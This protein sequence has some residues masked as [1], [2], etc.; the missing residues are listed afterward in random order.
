[1]KYIDIHA[2][3]Y[4]KPVPFVTEFCTAEELVRRYDK[5][6]IEAGFVLPVV[7][8][9]I[10]LPQANEDI[11][12]MAENFPGRLFPFCNLDPRALI[13]RA[14]ARLDTVLQYYKDK[15]CLGVG[16]IMPNMP[17]NDE[18]VQN[19]FA[20]A[21]KVGLPVT[22]DGSDRPEGDFGLYDLPGLPYLEHTLQRFPDLKFIAHGPV[23]WA[24]YTERRRP[25]Q[26]KA[27]FRNDGFQYGSPGGKGSG[28]ITCEGVAQELL[29]L[30][31][32]LYGEISDAAG[33]LRRD[34]DFAVKF[35]TEFQDKLFFGTDCCNVD[36]EEQ[37]NTKLWF[38]K[39]HES[40]KLPEEAWKKICRNNAIDF[41]HLPLV[42]A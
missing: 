1:M 26:C 38:D 7:N 18:R 22:T 23:F 41:F 6:G 36:T 8:S 2:H 34:E 21:E 11:L 19:L 5:Y 14:D 13:N 31:P 12:E 33:W 15:G 3:A 30:F 20:C 35:L 28:P 9:E 29:R 32:N 16:E 24:E 37:F 40:G 27:I 4:R 25:A 17:M 10:Y 42:K 39:L